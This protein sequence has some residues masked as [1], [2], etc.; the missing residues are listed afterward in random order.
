MDALVK[1]AADESQVREAGKRAGSKREQIMNDLKTVLSSPSGK[2][3]IWSLLEECGVY[4]SSM[5][6][7]A[8][9]YFNEGQRNIG[10][11][12]IAGI[13]ECDPQSLIKMMT[14]SK[15]EYL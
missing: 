4:K 11:K 5:T 7:D 15:N 8:H 12:I 14:D 2:R 9:T 3:Y 6:G 13:T 1:N 10:L